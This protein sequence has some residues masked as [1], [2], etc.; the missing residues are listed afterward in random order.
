MLKDICKGFLYW[1]FTSIFVIGS[2]KMAIMVNESSGFKAVFFFLV[3]AI[4]AFVGLI[5]L[6][7]L[8]DSLPKEEDE[9][10]G[11]SKM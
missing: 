10:N 7:V 1:L 9:K 4:S 6:H 5:M 8:G 3:M 2:V 11:L